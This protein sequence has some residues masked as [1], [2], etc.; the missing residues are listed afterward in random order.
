MTNGRAHFYSKNTVDI[1]Y[2]KHTVFICVLYF[3]GNVELSQE[4]TFFGSNITRLCNRRTRMRTNTLFDVSH[5]ILPYRHIRVIIHSM[6]I[7]QVTD[8]YPHS[9]QKQIFWLTSVCSWSFFFRKKSLMLRKAG[10]I[11]SKIL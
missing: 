2:N 7:D 9:K 4:E 11:T 1:H 8:L 10:F 5:L 3:S 6:L